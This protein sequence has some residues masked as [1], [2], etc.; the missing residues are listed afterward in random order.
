LRLTQ[1]P[2]TGGP[3]V[4]G[5]PYYFSITS[6]ALNYNALKFKDDPSAPLGTPGKYYID[7]LSFVGVVENVAKITQV[8]MGEDIYTPPFATQDGSQLSGGSRGNLQY[9]IVNKDALTGH[10]YKVSFTID[11]STTNMYSAFWNLTDETTGQNLIDSS[12]SFLYGS[13]DV[14]G[15]LTDGFLV[16]LSKEV[17]N[18]DTI[19]A[20]TS[21][22]WSDTKYYYV[23]PDMGDQSRILPGG[24]NKL[25]TL[26]GKYLKADKLRRVE[27]RFGDQG[28]AYRY[29][30]G[31]VGR[32]PPL[33]KNS[34]TYAGGVT[35]DNP[36]IPDPTILN[37]I[38][39]LGEGFVDV[40]FT[41]WIDDPNFGETRQLAVGFLE[42]N[43]SVA[44]GGNPDGV[45]DPGTSVDLSGEY[46]F[47]FDETYDPNGGQME[48]K[49]NFP[50]TSQVWADITGYTIPD[51]ASATADQRLIA[52]S[53]F[54]NTLYVVALS[55]L[56]STMFYSAGDK[57]EITLNNYP[58]T[59]D[60]AY[61]F[62]TRKN[63]ELTGDEEKALFE[64]VNVFPNPLYGFNPATSYSNTPPDD[65]FVTFSNLPQ[66][67]TITLYSLSGNKIKTL[68]TDDKASPA[69]PF[70]QWDLKNESG[71]RVASGLYIA[72]VNSPKYGQKILKF[73]LILPQ[74]QLQKY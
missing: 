18:I 68:T 56:D 47:I 20:I 59:L 10:K 72:I 8:T 34:Y 23:S 24:G 7:A 52:K 28:K 51:D 39:K 6:Y 2:F 36:D 15:N 54:F 71:I 16:K 57:F 69:S 17:P 70:L 1:D 22:D 66:D 30:N 44:A 33:R 5:K 13:S 14:S 41:A 49:G 4:K 11:S 35:A 45:W 42:Q 19:T 38:G 12:K 60:D 40:P 50:A 46:I 65:P 9:D 43:P 61:E 26:K 29:L 25:S 53:P 37:S 48:Y 62:Q 55:R 67:I 21:E 3:L 74:K 64:K 63:G 27:L 58:Y 73:S 31:Y 32:V